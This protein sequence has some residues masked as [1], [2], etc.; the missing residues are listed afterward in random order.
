LESSVALTNAATG[1][2]LRSMLGVSRRRH[3]V[4][5]IASGEFVR[6]GSAAELLAFMDNVG[7]ATP[8]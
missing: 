5:H 3:S 8:R 6:F 1:D 7:R 4:E 2:P